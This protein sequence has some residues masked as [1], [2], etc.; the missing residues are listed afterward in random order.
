MNKQY[1][2]RRGIAHIPIICKAFGIQHYILC[3]GSRNAPLII[4]FSKLTDAKLY[5]ITDERSAGYFAIGIAQA[6][7]QPVVIVCTSG[8]AVLNLAPAVAEAY[9]QNLPLIV[10]SADR[11]SELIDQGDGQTIHQRNIFGPHVKFSTE[12]PVETI[13]ET[14]LWF[15]DRLLCTAIDAALQ[16]PCA[17]VHINIP[18]R[19]PLYHPITFEDKKLKI[20]KTLKVK[21]QPDPQEWENIHNL[22]NCSKKKL[23]VVGSLLQKNNELN[24]LLKQLS[25]RTDTIVI[26]ENLSNLSHDSFIYDPERFLAT[27]SA[28]EKEKLQPNL[29]ITIGNSIVSKRLKQYLRT[30]SPTEHWH[31]NADQPYNDTYKSLTKNIPFDAHDFFKFLIPFSNDPQSDYST[32]FIQKHTNIE[33]KSQELINTIPFSDL[34]VTDFLLNHLISET[35]LHLANS[36]PVRYAQLFPTRSDILYFSN[37]GTSGIDGCTSTCA[38]MAAVIDNPTTLLTGDLAFIYDSNALWNNYLSP[39]L[40]IIVL[41]NGE[42]NIFQMID[43]SEDIVPI[44]NYFTTPHRVKIKHLASAFG[45]S[46]FSA[47]NF[48]ELKNIFHDFQHAFKP[49]ILEITTDPKINVKSYKHYIKSLAS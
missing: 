45:L 35:H 8:T 30:F 39:H 13:Q 49:S 17:P 19:E 11:P 28:T 14:D 10:F 5:S 27:L 18:L 21:K 34:T 44:L 24:Y 43:T 7:G 26:A 23:I 22:W 46:Y 16:N 9:Y 40:K 32:Y 15:N 6:T 25:Q 48:E 3:P 37:R 31:I 29:L 4:A 41:N 36:M 33:K 20:I 12:L 38:G 42:G 2:H 47:K 1:L